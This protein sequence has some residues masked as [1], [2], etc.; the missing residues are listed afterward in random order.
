MRGS[1]TTNGSSSIATTSSWPDWKTM[2]DE[3]RPIRVAHIST[4]M[5]VGGA[6]E[7]T[8]LSVEGLDRYPEFEVTLISGIDDGPEGSL[9]PRA[10]TT[11]RLIVLPELR[12]E[13]SPINDARVFWR[14]WRLFRAERYHIVHT[15]STK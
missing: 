7:N 6:Q 13:V 2:S 14:L 9:L 12:R 3:A 4:Q 1:S 8:L 5:I 15:H 11:T 10:A